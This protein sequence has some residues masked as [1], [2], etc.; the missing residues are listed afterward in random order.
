[1]QYIMMHKTNA[2]NEAGLPPPMKV[3]EGMGGLIGE[4][5]SAGAFRAGEGLRQSSLGVRL[6]FVSGKRTI[7][8]GPFQGGNELVAG[9][10]IVRVQSIEEAVEWA[11]KFAGVVG[12][13]EIDIR[14]VTEA[15][16]LG[17]CPKPEGEAG[18]RF[19]L[20]HKADKNSEAGVPLATNRMVEMGK[21]VEEMKTAGV[22]VT[23][24]GLAPSS[25][26]VRLNFADGKR[27]VTDGPFAESKELIAGYC[28][29]EAESL[30]EAM[31]WST[32]F[33]E[34]IGDVEI[35][36]RPLYHASN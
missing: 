17:M 27:T 36:I 5:V 33:A 1:M 32:P 24:A 8:P 12:D 16:D 34:L 28:I 4:M 10:A 9:F 13:V 29:I 20:A 15:W 23:A 19:M 7:T 18:T 30:E 26:G 6:N 25:Q 2:D 3:I 35:D 31:K 14:P 21:L 11:T 22:M